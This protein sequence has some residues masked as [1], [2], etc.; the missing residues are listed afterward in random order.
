MRNNKAKCLGSGLKPEH[1]AVKVKGFENTGLRRSIC[2]RCL[3]AVPIK[4]STWVL[5]VHLAVHTN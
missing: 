2:P 5:W 1:P 4:Q 3:K